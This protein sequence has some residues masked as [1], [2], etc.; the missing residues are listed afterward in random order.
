MVANVIAG[1]VARGAIANGARSSLAPLAKNAGSK[2]TGILKPDKSNGPKKLNGLES[3]RDKANL[4]TFRDMANKKPINDERIGEDQQESSPTENKQSFSNNSS[5]LDYIKSI[6]N[7]LSTANQ[8]S[9][10]IETNTGDENRK[11][12]ILSDKLSSKYE[13]SNGEIIKSDDPT[14]D[15]LMVNKDQSDQNNLPSVAEQLAPKSDE[16]PSDG[17]L[18]NKSGKELESTK[19]N[20]VLMGLTSLGN[21]I[22][23]GF[24]AS[25]NAVDKVTGFLFKMSL[26]QAVRA[27]A[28]GV[29]IFSVIALIDAVRIYWSIWGEDIK[30]KISEWTEIFKGWWDKFTDWFTQFGSF[31]TAFETMGANLME[32]KNAWTSGDF[33]ALILAIGRGIK[34]VGQELSVLVGRAVAGAIASLLRKFGFNDTADSIEAGAIR[35]QQATTSNKLTPEEQRKLAEDQVKKEEKDGKTATERGLLDFIPA[36]WRNI[37]GNL[38]DEEYSQVQKEQ[39]DLDARKNLSHED[40]V[41][42]TMATNEAREALERYKKYADKANSDNAGQMAKVDKYKKEAID[43]LGNKDLNFT[44]ETKAELQRQFNAIKVKDAPAKPAS[45]KESPDTQKAQ[46]INKAEADKKADK[47]TTNNTAN[48]HN[49]VVKNNKQVHVQAPVTGTKAPGVYKA[50]GVN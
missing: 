23:S 22:T 26:T 35:I 33:P 30:A 47:A 50:T 14:S 12:Q 10:G 20:P 32:I 24:K 38:S 1:A 18:D 8:I 13:S 16:K 44:P 29:A 48:V 4:K 36:K 21:A 45:A 11:L 31:T 5:G 40:K 19:M 34:D 25:V 6:D 42:S 46:A 28:L 49:T 17:L 2:V 43:Y 39:K 9:S 37:V 27:A 41:K 15:A 7:K 3:L